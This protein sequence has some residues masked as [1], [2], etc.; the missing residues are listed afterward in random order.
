MDLS[1][2]KDNKKHIAFKKIVLHKKYNKY[3]NR[4]NRQKLAIITN[5]P[6]PYRR[7]LF[8]KLSNSEKFICKVFF[9]AHSE[10]NRNWNYKEFLD[11]PHIFVP[12]WAVKRRNSAVTY[13]NISL[14]NYLRK[15]RPDCIIIGG[16][17][18]SAVLCA[19][20]KQLYGCKVYIWWAGTMLSE[21]NKS[22]L[23]VKFRKWLFK[24]ADGFLCYS[25]YCEKYLKL[26]GVQ[27]NSITVMGNNTFD[28]QKYSNGRQA[29]RKNISNDE[30]NQFNILV[31][32]QLIRRKNI[33]RILETFH[34]ISQKY[35]NI[36]L[37]IAG[38]GPEESILKDFVNRNN[39]HNVYF[40]GNVQPE[41]LKKYYVEADVLLSIARMDQWP[42]VVN[43]AMSFG[44]PVIAST[45]SGIDEN[46]LQDGV[47]GYLVDLEDQDMLLQR[48]E[49]LILH[50]EQ[51]NSMGQEAY[52]V[53]RKYDVHYAIQ[54]IE[55][56]ILNSSSLK[57]RPTP[58]RCK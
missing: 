54:K 24:R 29:S 40:L 20:Y 10:H 41:D 26:L 22:K 52:R 23:L 7:Y 3:K 45:T 35:S 27:A 8:V 47:N 56:S 11:Y 38:I 2:E 32:S 21:A 36:V 19:V 18:I 43:E 15:Y 4:L 30:T 44:V 1:S 51:T 57:E 55:N 53:A 6:T 25:H 9:T 49:T 5:I 50:P 48:L 58:P 37:K 16:A 34:I 46:F 13:I 17:S 42:Q 31:V 12:G 28:I 39:L 33:S 14:F